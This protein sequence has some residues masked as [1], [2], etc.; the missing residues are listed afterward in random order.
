[1]LHA[2]AELGVPWNDMLHPDFA[3]Q[4]DAFMR[5]RVAPRSSDANLL[6]WCSDNELGWFADTLFVYHIGQPPSS[7]TRKTLIRL[8]RQHYDNEFPKLEAD[9]HAEG[10]G[11]FDELERGGE[12]RLRAGGD[13]MQVVNSFASTLAQHYY[14]TMH[15]AIRRY[16]KNHLILGDR[17]HSYT[18]DVVAQ[19]AGPYVDVVTTNY[20]WP[21]WTDGRLPIHYLEHLHQLSGK[22]ILITEYYVAASEN[23][24][25]NKNSGDIFTTVQTQSDRAQRGSESPFDARRASV[26]GRRPLVPVRG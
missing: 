9:F 3:S 12:L 5:E 2:G 13:A 1:M 17:Y 19:A 18:P 20:D 4:I 25:G 10:V 16:D 11:N 8:L 15:D 21:D 24:S 14:R 7:E 26:C 23:R 22:P 6:G